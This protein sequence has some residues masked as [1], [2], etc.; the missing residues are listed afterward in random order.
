MRAIG[1][2]SKTIIFKI[3]ANKNISYDDYAYKNYLYVIMFFFKKH[4]VVSTKLTCECS[5]KLKLLT[6]PSFLL[7]HNKTKIL[8]GK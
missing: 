5:C 6:W 1:N 8:R 3:F 7:A 4:N 2:I